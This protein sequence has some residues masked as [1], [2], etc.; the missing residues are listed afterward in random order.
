MLNKSNNKKQKVIIIGGGGAGLFSGATIKQL[1]KN[2]EV[3]LISNEEL[4]C[5]CSGPYVIKDMAKMKDTIMPDT[6]ITQFGIK[7]LKGTV[8]TIDNKTKTLRYGTENGTAKITYDTLI[9]ATGARAFM[10]PVN[11]T[12]LKNVFS[13]RTPDDIK[14]INRISK[15]IKNVTVIGG[16]VIG[17]EMS[18]VL[19]ERGLKVNMLL[20]EK[21]VFERLADNEYCDKIET[22]LKNNKINILNNS[23]ITNIHGKTKVESITYKKANIEHKFKTD[24]VIF[25]AGVKANMELAKEIDI[26]TNQFGIIVDEHMKTSKKNIYA[27]GDVCCATNKVTCEKTPSQLAT[28]SVIQG[29]I[30]GKNIVGMKTKYAGHTSATAMGFF[31]KEYGSCGINEKTAIEKKIKYYVGNATTTNMYQD[32]SRAE[33]VDVKLIFNE[34][35]NKIIGLE[36]FGKDI[37]GTVNLIS[38]AIIQNSTINDLMNLDYASHPTVSPWPFMNPIIMCCEDAQMN[39]MMKNQKQQ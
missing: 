16:G 14:K 30:A 36:C 17:V 4:F 10:P 11:G 27:V 29:K 8:K 2:H 15:K 5:R 9:F 31:N 35:S 39:L 37:V 24:M 1:S 20:L 25:A 33:Q 26:K 7:L 13:V 19:R 23:M 12:N 22:I 3:Y 6:M 18:S 38:Y 28:N 21:K 32:L 34:K